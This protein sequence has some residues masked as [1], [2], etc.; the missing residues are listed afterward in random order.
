MKNKILKFLIGILVL[1]IMAA[2]MVYSAPNARAAPAGPES[3]IAWNS[4]MLRTVITV[5]QQ[6]PPPSFVY[7]TYVQTAVYNAVIAI[8]GGY[9][10]YKSNIARDPSASVD[11]AVA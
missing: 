7:A 11:A 8:E 10:P 1:I 4:I 6:P 5:G 3:V 2:G 9:Q